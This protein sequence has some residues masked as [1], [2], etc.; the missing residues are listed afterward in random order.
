[1][2]AQSI[3]YDLGT[4]GFTVTDA[5]AVVHDLTGIFAA[6]SPTAP[7]SLLYTSDTP[8]LPVVRVNLVA[9]VFRI[10]LPSGQILTLDPKTSQALSRLGWS[11]PRA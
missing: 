8:P 3:D 9:A 2:A 11:V 4:G 6:A 10:T 5:A 7:L 1:M